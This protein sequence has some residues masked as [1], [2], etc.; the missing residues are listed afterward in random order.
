MPEL[1]AAYRRYRDDG[2]VIVG[3]NLQEAADRVRS[4]ADEYGIEFPLVIDRS[5]QVGNVW[6]IGGA[7]SGLPSSYFID[8]TGVVRAVSLGPLTG[9]FLQD[10]LAKILP[11]AAA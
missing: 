6:R 8:S 2:L 10:N 5:G 3:V 11:E 1:V 9:D 4:F 7:F